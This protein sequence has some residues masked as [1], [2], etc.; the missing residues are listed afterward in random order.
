M[1]ICPT[2]SQGNSATY[3]STLAVI[4]PVY[5]VEEYLRQCIDSIIGQTYTSLRVILVDDGSPDQSGAI[6]DEYAANDERI[7]VI[8][9]ANGGLSSARNEGLKHISGC[10]Y[11]TYVDSDDWLERTFAEHCIRALEEDP[12]LDYAEMAY[13]RE[14]GA[15][16]P[17]VRGTSVDRI[18]T[19]DQALR[20]MT[21]S[22]IDGVF[23]TAW[24]K[25]FRTELIQGMSFIE[26]RTI[27]DQPY[28]LECALRIQSMKVLREVGYHYRIRTGS[29]MLSGQ[30]AR[31]LK[32]QFQNLIE[33]R[34]RLDTPREKAWATR[35][36]QEV[37]W[38][39]RR[40]YLK[41]VG[42]PEEEDILSLIQ[43]AASA[44]RSSCTYRGLGWG[45]GFKCR[46]YIRY[47]RGYL[48]F[49]RWTHR[50][51]D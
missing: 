41:A 37:I 45:K 36:L 19:S 25:V 43:Q 6:C 22:K 23:M 20:E 28:I 40:T 47:P 24:G 12:R 9:K 3:R 46:L 17:E 51:R 2:N 11:V 27:E 16:H 31:L 32:D 50:R 35:M 8:H 14:D 21:S 34:E 33:L 18:C 38:W 48:R 49:Y 4:V 15:V 13:V 1:Y 10:D 26:G 29:I 30:D 44:V 42:S 39:S 5:K 7:Q